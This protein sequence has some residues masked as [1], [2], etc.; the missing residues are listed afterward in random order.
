LEEIF[1]CEKGMPYFG[2]SVSRARF[3]AG[4]VLPCRRT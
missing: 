3:C 4:V 2:Y 1:S